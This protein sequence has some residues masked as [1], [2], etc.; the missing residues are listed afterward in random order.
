MGFDLRL[1]KIS[2]VV[3]WLNQTEHRCL[4]GLLAIRINHMLT[5]HVD[6]FHT[7]S[8]KASH[9]N[10]GHWAQ[11]VSKWSRPHNFISVLKLGLSSS[12]LRIPPK[13][14]VN[15]FLIKFLT[16]PNQDSTLCCIYAADFVSNQFIVKCFHLS[17]N[18]LSFNPI[19]CRNAPGKNWSLL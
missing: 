19:W 13:S 18:I 4:S 17:G 8:I 9:S 3:I 11:E 5:I 6:T 10:F 14:L 12:Y 15:W 16:R 1:I 2:C 7:L